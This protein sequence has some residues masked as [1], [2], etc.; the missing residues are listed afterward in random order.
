MNKLNPTQ[1]ETETRYFQV[2][3]TGEPIYGI[4]F[5]DTKIDLENRTY[6]YSTEKEYAASSLPTINE[7]VADGTL[8]VVDEIEE[9]F[10][11]GREVDLWDFDAVI[12]FAK[13]RGFNIE[14]EALIHNVENWKM[15]YKS[16]YRGKECHVFTPCGCNPLSFCVTKLDERAGWQKTYY[17]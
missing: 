12:A 11:T 15:D 5:W 10:I 13:E 14:R 8:K 2:V 6:I 1:G 7:L 9:L 16:G 17:A 4:Y 3:K